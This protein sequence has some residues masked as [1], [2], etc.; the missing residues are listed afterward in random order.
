MTKQAW[1]QNAVITQD[2]GFSI[3]WKPRCP[4]CGH[5][6][7]LRDCGGTATEGSRTRYYA[8]CDKCGKSFDVVASRG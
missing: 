6:P 3:R 4:Y 8:S 7:P 5:I 2:S 1:A